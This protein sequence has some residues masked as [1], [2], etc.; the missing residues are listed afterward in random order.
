MDF[1]KLHR[2]GLFSV[3]NLR[4]AAIEA[5]VPEMLIVKWCFSFDDRK[6][7]NGGQA[8]TLEIKQQAVVKSGDGCKLKV[9]HFYLP[10][11]LHGEKKEEKYCLTGGVGG[12]LCC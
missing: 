4:F 2:I 5:A 1:L 3:A 12:E 8:M 10:L 6:Q 7:L 11:L 9:G